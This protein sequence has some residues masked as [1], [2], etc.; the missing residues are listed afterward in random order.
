MKL[1]RNV[2]VLVSTLMGKS[3]RN[4]KQN[5]RVGWHERDALARVLVMRPVGERVS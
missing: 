4:G 5:A 3:A 2:E 1:Q